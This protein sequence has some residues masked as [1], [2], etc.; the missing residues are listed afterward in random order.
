MKI[1]NSID[2]D[3]D[4]AFEKLPRNKYGRVLVDEPKILK[5]QWVKISYLLNTQ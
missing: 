1:N 5:P 2:Y 4:K 3:V